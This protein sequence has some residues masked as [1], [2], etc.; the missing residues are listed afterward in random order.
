MNIF[1]SVLGVVAIVIVGVLALDK[2]FQW[3]G[4]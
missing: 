3:L 2:L 4:W 1:L